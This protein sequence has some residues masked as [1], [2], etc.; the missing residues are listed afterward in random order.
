[1]Q[2]PGVFLICFFA[3]AKGRVD[4]WR[5]GGRRGREGGDGDGDGVLIL[6]S[7]PSKKALRF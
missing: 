7:G 5:L 2:C 6:S 4:R 3:L 1:M